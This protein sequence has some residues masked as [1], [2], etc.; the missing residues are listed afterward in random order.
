MN[1]FLKRIHSVNANVDENGTGM[2]E[3]QY[4][5]DKQ[6]E[7]NWH[8]I[9]KCE[10]ENVQV[11]TAGLTGSPGRTRTYNPAVNSRMLCH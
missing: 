2:I 1:T 3:I 9:R 5:A 8:K 6:L 4:I 11:R 10:P 7:K